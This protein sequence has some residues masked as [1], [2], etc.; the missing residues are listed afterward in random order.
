M[1]FPKSCIVFPFFS[2]SL[3]FTSSH[4]CLLLL[5]WQ[6]SA[7][8][9]M[10]Q[11]AT[12]RACCV[13]ES[14]QFSSSAPVDLSRKGLPLWPLSMHPCAS[15]SSYG[16]MEVACGRMWLH[17]PSAKSGQGRPGCRECG[18]HLREQD[19]DP[20]PPGLAVYFLC[21][22]WSSLVDC[23]LWLHFYCLVSFMIFFFL[24]TA[25]SRWLLDS[26]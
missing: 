3:I 7:C 20:P 26:F 1:I 10:P 6:E 14:G 8:V 5:C 22:P 25:P 9:N 18:E 12:G 16:C 19:T 2:W 17:A 11:E 21:C 24:I 23:L 15:R 4:L 13:S